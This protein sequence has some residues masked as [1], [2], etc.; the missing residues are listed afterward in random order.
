V[1]QIEVNPFLYR[2]DCIDYFADRDIITVAYKPFL[3]GAAASHPAVAAVAARYEGVSAG[4]VLLKWLIGKGIAV[5]PKSTNPGRMA[6]NL[7]C[8]D[9]CSWSLTSEDEL[10]LDSLYDSSAGLAAFEAH[11]LKRAVQDPEGP[12]LCLGYGP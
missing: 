5:L 8:A 9:E 2:R 11:F 10:E 4:S 7:R 1:N 3:R 12:T 6:E